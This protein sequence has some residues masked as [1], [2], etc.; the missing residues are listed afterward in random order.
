MPH[1]GCQGWS[2]GRCVRFTSRGKGSLWVL[3]FVDEFNL[4][5]Q[6]PGFSSIILQVLATLVVFGVDLKRPKGAG[7]ACYPW[8]GYEL[9]VADWKLGASASRA[10][11]LSAWMERLLVS[12]S[13][14]LGEFAEA[15][16]RATFAYG[17]FEFDRPFLAPLFA[18]ASSGPPSAVRPLPVFVLLVL[19]FL[20]E[21]L[22]VRRAHACAESAA[23]DQVEGLRV[24]AKAEGEDVAVAGWLPTGGGRRWDRHTCLALVLLPHQPTQ[25]SLGLPSRRQTEPDDCGP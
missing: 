19:T 6:G 7:G 5:A 3:I 23:G 25:R 1:I 18:F 10:R 22:Q 13:T 15:L 14:Q 21:R 9:D 2:P 12:Q 24:D 11:W 4:I 20:H 16:G 8:I 17:A